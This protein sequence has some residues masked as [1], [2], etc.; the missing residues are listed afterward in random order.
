MNTLPPELVRTGGRIGWHRDTAVTVA[1]WI[2]M[3]RARLER[4]RSGIIKH[5]KAMGDPVLEID[6]RAIDRKLDC[7]LDLIVSVDDGWDIHEWG[8]AAQ[9]IATLL[10]DRHADPATTDPPSTAIGNGQRE[11]K[12]T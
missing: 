12:G 11:S 8:L 6:T 4:Q 9:W 3:H 2:E 10:G 7:L 5:R 1:T